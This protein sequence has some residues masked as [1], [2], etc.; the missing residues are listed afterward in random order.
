[1]SGKRLVL[2]H[3]PE[4][5]NE[6]HDIFLYEKMGVLRHFI[7]EVRKIRY[8]D[9]LFNHSLAALRMARLTNQG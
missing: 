7:E 8:G 9:D 2:P 1:M 5:G 6:K 4:A 3:I